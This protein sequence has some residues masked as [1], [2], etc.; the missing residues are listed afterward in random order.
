MADRRQLVKRDDGSPSVK[1][2]CELVERNRS[3][4]YYEP[5]GEPPETFALMREIDEIYTDHP[6]YGSRR[7]EAVL[8]RR[9]HGVGRG[10][11]VRLMRLMGIEGK[12]PGPRTTRPAPGHKVHPNLLKNMTVDGPCQVWASD[13]TYLPMPKGTMYLTV[14][15]DWY[16][17]CIL[18]WELSNS[19]DGDFCVRALETA[20]EGPERPQVFHTD[21][22]CQ[23][24][25]RDF[26]GV[27]GANG[28]AISM[29]GRGR[30]YD[31]IFVERFWRSLKHELIYKNDFQTVPELR[32]A[33][34]EYINHYNTDRPQQALGHKTPWEIHVRGL[35]DTPSGNQLES[36]CGGS[37]SPS[38][39]PPTNQTIHSRSG[40]S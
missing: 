23:Y 16:S 17:R 15:M 28:I 39:T 22:G 26:T 38:S 31:N 35:D 7:I 40:G 5:L 33:V 32:R 3:S 34:S 6:C 25:M 24:T 19:L 21:Q 9:G 18:S 30:A 27:L 11:V 36:K 4:Y 29:S 14:V 12:R 10:R 2:Q 1:R 20:L 8:C 13:I 37:Q